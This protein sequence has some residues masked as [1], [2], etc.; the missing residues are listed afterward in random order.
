MMYRALSVFPI[1][2]SFGRDARQLFLR[3]KFDV[4]DRLEQVRLEVPAGLSR[5][6]NGMKKG[7]CCPFETP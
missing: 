7:A 5:Q 6:H 4:A 3:D 2:S 1:C